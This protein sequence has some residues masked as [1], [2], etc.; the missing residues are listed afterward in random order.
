MTLISNADVGDRARE[1][2]VD[3]EAEQRERRR[4]RGCEAHAGAKADDVVEIAGIA[5]RPGEIAAVRDR[6]HARRERRARAAARAAGALRDVVG[7][8]GRAVD[9][10]VGVRAH[11]ELGHVGLADRNHAGA[12]HALDEDRVLRRHGVF[13]DRRAA[14]ELEA[15]GRLQILEGRRQAVQRRQLAAPRERA[16]AAS[17]NARHSSSGSFATMAFNVGLTVLMR[18]RCAAMT[19]RA[20]TWRVRISRASSVALR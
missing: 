3:R 12:P 15:D 20:D 19:S 18:S 16:S 11:A 10:V 9:L 2:P 14:G 6:Q 7:V 8:Q 5:Q 1:R 17:A 4:P 13:V